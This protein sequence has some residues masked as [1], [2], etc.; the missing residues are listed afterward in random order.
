M[1]SNLNLFEKTLKKTGELVLHVQF[2]LL[3]G[4][5]YWYWVEKRRRH[6]LQFNMYLI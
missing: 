5:G 3:Q 2:F 4:D 1:S 6:C